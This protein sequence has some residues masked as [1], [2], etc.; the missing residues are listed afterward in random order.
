MNFEKIRSEIKSQ[1]KK[2]KDQKIA[3]RCLQLAE[4][5]ARIESEDF[6]NLTKFAARPGAGLKAHKKSLRHE[7]K[8][9]IRSNLDP[10]EIKTFFPAW[11]LPFIVQVILSTVISWIVRRMIDNLTEDDD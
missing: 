7:C 6:S 5:W 9:F 3:E 10:K 8:E 4:E 11:V 1:Y 2:E